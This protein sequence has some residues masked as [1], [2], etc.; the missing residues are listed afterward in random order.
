[1]NRVKASL[2]D[3]FGGI[4]RPLVIEANSVL[5][6]KHLAFEDWAKEIVREAEKRPLNKTAG[7]ITQLL[8]QLEFTERFLNPQEKSQWQPLIM[9]LRK[10]RHEL[11][12]VKHKDSV[13]IRT[14]EELYDNLPGRISRNALKKQ[15]G[16]EQ[17]LGDN[18]ETL[19]FAKAINSSGV[20]DYR[21]SSLLGPHT[22]FVVDP[23][24]KSS[25]G[26]VKTW[27]PEAKSTRK[28][29]EL[30]PTNDPRKMRDFVRMNP[31]L[32]DQEALM[33]GEM[34]ALG[35]RKML[36]VPSGSADTDPEKVTILLY[37]TSG[38]MGGN[39]MYFQAMYISALV[40]RALSDIGPSGRVRH[41]VFLMG[42]D[43][44]VHTI[45]Q[46]TSP[47]EAE[48]VVRNAKHNN[49]T[50]GGTNIEVALLTAADELKRANSTGDKAMSRAT[51]VLVSDGGSTV[52]S[53]KVRTAFEAVSAGKRTKADLLLAFVAI[54][55][56]NPDLLRLTE[57][58]DTLG[59]QKGMYIQWDTEEITGILKAAQAKS[60]PLNDFWSAEQFKNLN[61]EIKGGL[62]AIYQAAN[63]VKNR[64]PQPKANPDLTIALAQSFVERLRGGGHEEKRVGAYSHSL[65]L[66]RRALNMIGNTLDANE[67][68]TFIRELLADWKRYF[69]DDMSHYDFHESTHLKF[70][71]QWVH[72]GLAGRADVEG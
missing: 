9:A 22:D 52:N 14:A 25:Y 19:N 30:L 32:S 23:I 70:I 43:E 7:E 64:Q 33:R 17:G 6:G 69:P 11:G 31:S 34:M 10:L 4:I 20:D 58:A 8:R 18:V 48:A 24:Q 67:R 1:M 46:V 53:D 56:T 2:D 54:N 35:R 55:G 15:F 61:P 66:I 50:T 45:T 36:K 21:L 40:D 27:I 49:Q 29:R 28:R 12:K 62:N 39:P 38:S 59:A 37:D 13:A 72:E 26:Y 41:R 16:F 60:V 65:R 51:V 68:E 44:K 3:E 57:N 47:K 71:L 42:F 63:Q 5:A